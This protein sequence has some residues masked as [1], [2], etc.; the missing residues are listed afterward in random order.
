MR[1][2]V[3]DNNG[4]LDPYCDSHVSTFQAVG[5]AVAST[6]DDFG[7]IPTVCQRRK[8]QPDDEGSLED[9]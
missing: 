4:N 2:V 1:T 7:Q 8:V 6:V 9:A 3:S 5:R